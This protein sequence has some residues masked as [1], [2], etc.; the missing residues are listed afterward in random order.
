MVR[1]RQAG[2]PVRIIL[3][4]PRQVGWSTWSEAEGFYEINTRPNRTGLVVSADT[5][6]TNFVFAMTKLYHDQMPP[7]LK[8]P[9]DQSNRKEIIYA[10]PHRSK[11]ITQ[12]AGKDVLGRGGTVHFFH[13][14]EVAFWQRAKEGLAAVLQMVP[15]GDV[16]TSVIL[17]STANGVGGSF[18][19]MFWQAYE[20]KQKEDDLSGYLPV[21]FPWHKFPAYKTLTPKGFNLYEDEEDI[22]NFFKLTDEQIFWRRLKI[23]ELGGDVQL[24]KQSSRSILLLH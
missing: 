21:F 16:T 20:R 9:T 1:Q 22:K 11:F 12:T 4:K 18:H 13:A 19:D 3:L 7:D 14:S 10:A 17:E 15:Q 8:R 2:Y 23:H 6:S 24:F 5:D